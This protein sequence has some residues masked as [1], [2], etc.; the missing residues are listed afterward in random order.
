METQGPSRLLRTPLK[1]ILKKPYAFYHYLFF[2]PRSL[3]VLSS[4]IRYDWIVRCD[5]FGHFSRTDP[6]RFPRTLT[7]GA[8]S[9]IFFALAAATIGISIVVRSAVIFAPN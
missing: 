1:D 2:A 6:S 9:L 5:Q 3:A 8:L 7:G 4:S